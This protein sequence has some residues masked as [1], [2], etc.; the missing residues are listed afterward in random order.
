MS[1]K[2]AW[3]VLAGAK[4]V[5]D[6]AIFLGLRSL[7]FE[8]YGKDTDLMLLSATTQVKKRYSCY[9]AIPFFQF[10]EQ[11]YFWKFLSFLRQTDVLVYG[12][13]AMITYDERA[14]VLLIAAGILGVPIYICGVGV[15]PKKFSS[16]RF[17]HWLTTVS[18]QFADYITVRDLA[19]K[20]ILK[21]IGVNKDI[22]V[23]ADLAYVLK[24]PIKTKIVR[25][26]KKIAINVKRHNNF[27]MQPSDL[28]KANRKLYLSIANMADKMISQGYDI[29]F[30][31]FN[32]QHDLKFINEIIGTMEHGT[33]AKIVELECNP[34]VFAER[35]QDYDVLVSMRKHHVILAN[36]V[37]VP[38]VPVGGD[39]AMKWQVKMA[40]S[41][42]FIDPLLDQK[43]LQKKLIDMVEYRLKT[44]TSWDNS[45][46][47][48]AQRD[49]A[50]ENII[51]LKKLKNVKKSMIRFW[52]LLP[53]VAIAVMIASNIKIFL[54]KLTK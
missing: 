38:N 26:K 17:K 22:K 47:M 18:L 48:K 24:F 37:G 11:K 49:R 41:N 20:K 29:H 31:L 25:K 2:V 5:G 21:S 40:G 43:K 10:Y 14:S 35:I 36:I 44:G 4:N 33:D 46:Y 51:P 23:T 32:K 3:G 27:T 15:A 6:E 50:G 42:T 19:G 7:I 34:S 9:D 39:P 16:S 53:V 28:N 45:K 1:K 52:L 30:I 8:E 54:V 12:G 13:G